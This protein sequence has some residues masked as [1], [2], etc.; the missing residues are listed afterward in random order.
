M[1]K[2]QQPK[3]SWGTAIQA[4]KGLILLIILVCTVL[5]TGAYSQESGWS[6]FIA[7]T[8]VVNL[9]EDSTLTAPELPLQV[10]DDRETPGPVLGIRQIKKWRYIPVDQYLV[11]PEPLSAAL[12]KCLP[13]DITRPGDTLVIDNISLW[14]DGS[15][16]F[17]QGWTLNGRT[18]LVDGGGAIVRDWQWEHRVKKKRKQKPEDAIGRL[19]GEW[20]SAQ[21][22]ALNEDISIHEV[23]PYRYRRQL[24]FRVDTII[25]P[26]GYILDGRLSLDFPADQLDRY[27]RGA[28]GMSIYY[29]KSSRHQDYSHRCKEQRWLIRLSTSWLGRLNCSF[30]VGGNSYNPDKF[31]YV[32]WCNILLVN[33]GLIAAVEYRPRYHKGLFADAGLHQSINVLPLPEVVPRYETGLL[34]TVGVVLP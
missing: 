13:I 2:T 24:L 5:V 1:S 21:A 4:H 30:R 8:L 15:P 17:L 16:L 22:K 23:S 29:R 28:P 31:D 27:I 6:R 14:Y 12:V 3:I 34:L 26:D 20:M 25:L 7:D 11:L 18:R 33:I 32:D 9:P 10:R 19:M